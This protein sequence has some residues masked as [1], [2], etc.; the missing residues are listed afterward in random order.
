MI[1]SVYG[2]KQ[3]NDNLKMNVSKQTKQ[4][5]GKPG[6]PRQG[7]I[8]KQTESDPDRDREIIYQQKL[9][10]NELISDLQESLN[11]MGESFKDEANECRS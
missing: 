3:F 2:V 6:I 1:E 10:I 11:R 7:G 8:L 4:K 5:T 9:K